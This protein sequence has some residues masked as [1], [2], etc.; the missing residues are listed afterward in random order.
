[1]T[2]ESEHLLASLRRVKRRIVRAELALM[3]ER[4]REH[5]IQRRREARLKYVIGGDVVAGSDRDEFEAT[6]T[7]VL[8]RERAR[9]R[10]KMLFK[11]R[12]PEAAEEPPSD[13]EAPAAAGSG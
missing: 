4:A 6:S 9:K 8:A 5:E 13:D 1:M 10:D 7:L 3:S 12:A 11:G 2:T